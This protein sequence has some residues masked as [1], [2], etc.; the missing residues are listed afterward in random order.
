ME[1]SLSAS[2]IEFGWFVHTR[3]EQC[4]GKTDLWKGGKEEHV[5]D[6][7]RKLGEGKLTEGN[8]KTLRDVNTKKEIMK[9]EH[10]VLKVIPRENNG[11]DMTSPKQKG[12]SYS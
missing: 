11:M 2:L 3:A 10:G 4:P 5:T 8:G 6:E 1:F 7:K 12:K 9:R